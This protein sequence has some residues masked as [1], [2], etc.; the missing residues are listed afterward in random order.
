MKGTKKAEV[1]EVIKTE[2]VI[3]DGTKEN[4]VRTIIQYWDKN[5][6]LICSQEQEYH[7]EEMSD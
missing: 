2:C 6:K 1:V 3:G 7:G 5:G 4:P